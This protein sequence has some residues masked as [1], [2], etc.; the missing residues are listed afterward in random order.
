VSLMSFVLPLAVLYVGVGIWLLILARKQK[1]NCHRA[2]HE[3]LTSVSP[4]HDKVTS[5]DRVFRYSSKDSL[6]SA[7]LACLVLIIGVVALGSRSWS[8]SDRLLGGGSALAG[9]LYLLRDAF[10]H[11]WYSATV[12]V[13]R[14]IIQDCGRQEIPYKRIEN[15]QIV[16]IHSR[17]ASRAACKIKMADGTDDGA[18]ITVDSQI[19]DFLGFVAAIKSR[20]CAINPTA[21][22]P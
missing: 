10:C 20:L 1:R 4:Q 2:A 6:F 12:S 19:V 18:E 3:I 17:L 7:P 5:E 14:L 11:L 16:W 22:D 21:F 8:P 13:D 15:V 9:A